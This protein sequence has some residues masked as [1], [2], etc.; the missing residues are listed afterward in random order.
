MTW[1]DRL[2]HSDFPARKVFLAWLAVCAILTLSALSRILVGQFPD[3]DDVL[4]LVQV[5]DLVNGQG[6]FDPVQYRIDPL[7]GTPMHWSRLVDLPLY[8]VIAGLTPLIGQGAAESVAIILLPL[9]TFGIAAAA[10]ARLAWRLLGTNAAIFTVLACGFLPAL[11]FQFQ[12]QRIDH[13]GWQIASVAIALWATG[14]RSATGGGAVAGLAMAFGFSVSL[15]VLPMAAAF[16]GILFL[17]WWRDPANRHWLASYMVALSLGLSIF[18]ATTRGLSP[19]QYCDAIGPA[20]LGFFAVAA[21]G[22][23]VVS[24]SKPLGQL[25]LLMSFGVVGALALGSFA[26]AS[27]SCLATPFAS[28]DSVVDRLWYRLVLEGQPLFA[29]KA[30]TFIPAVIQLVAA[31][32][33]TF[34]LRRQA[35]EWKRDWWGDYLLL[36]LAS[37]GLSL[38]VARS[39]AFASI[40]ASLPLGWLAATLLEKLRNSR[41][42]QARFGVAVA[43]ILLLAP[44]T[45]VTLGARIAQTNSA[46]ERAQP[47]VSSGKCL[48]RDEAS[49]LNRLPAGTI[50]GPLDLGPTILLQSHHS[51]V[52]TGHHRAETAMADVITAF[53]SNPVQ[54]RALVAKH[55]ADYMVLCANLSEANVYAHEAPQGLMAHLQAGQFPAWLEPVD[56]GGSN[57]FLVFRVKD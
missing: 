4:R 14:W 56:L 52:A 33:A 17:R 41:A 5:R 53:T 16:A 35:E 2:P 51:V 12:P 40:I 23:L 47:A 44:M 31:V 29:Q 6:W 9:L 20:H 43:F 42:P 3:P 49:R 8:L 30:A 25:A 13:H 54:A 15:E 38:L 39:L 27:P 11:L 55:H 57:D 36:L 26:L 21:T 45:P 46:T 24:R 48:I 22:T 50:F 1:D 34:V 19:I 7:G 37:I 18:Y 28:L 32:A 10:M